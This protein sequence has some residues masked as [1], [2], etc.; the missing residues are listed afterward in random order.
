MKKLLLILFLL[1][2][3]SFSQNDFRKM[4]WGESQE[5]FKEKYPDINFDKELDN[6]YTGYSYSDY[7]AGIKAVITYLFVNDEFV[8][9]NY[10][11]TKDRSR[12]SSEDYLKDY[13]TISF[14]LSEKYSMTD[15][16]EW[17]DN[18]FEG[19]PNQLSFAISLGHV[20]LAENTFT[21][22]ETFI[23]HTLV[24]SEGS[25][26]HTLSYMSKEAMAKVAES[27]N[28]DF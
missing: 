14:I 27:N 28:N 10:Y 19:Q 4:N 16:R 8:L 5:I 21:E 23:N 22:S 9:G 26:E 6:D 25:L 17:F 7:I 3:V 2:L 1:P 18:S 11:F 13:N 24:K 15:T 12:A 20:S